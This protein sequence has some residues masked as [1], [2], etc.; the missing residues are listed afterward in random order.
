[1]VI[2]NLCGL[3]I[4]MN[5]QS[6]LIE[7]NILGD[8]IIIPAIMVEGKK[9][10]LQV[11]IIISNVKMSYKDWVLCM[12]LFPW[13]GLVWGAHVLDHSGNNLTEVPTAP[14]NM[15]I[16]EINL[17]NNHIQE[18]HRD[19][20]RNYTQLVDIN[21]DQNGLRAIHDGVFNHINTLRVL[22][23]QH[24]VIV[25][26]PTD[27][28]PST[29]ILHKILL[30]EAIAASQILTHPY[31]SSFT[32]LVGLTLHNCNIGNISDPFFPPNIQL[33][34]LGYSKVAKFPLLSISSPSLTYVSMPNQKFRTIPEKAVAGLFRLRFMKLTNNEINNFPNF[35]HCKRLT[36]IYLGKNK[37]SH[38]PR[39]HIKGLDKIRIMHLD[40]NLL[41]NMTDISSLAPLEEFTVGHNMISEIPNACIVGLLKMK[42][43]KCNDNYI[44]V[45][46]NIS[47]YFPL[48]KELFVQGN[49]LKSLPDM[50]DMQ[51][52]SLLTVAQNSYVCN[53]SLCWLR[54]LPWLNPD[55]T[56]LKDNPVCDQPVL[57]SDT[58]IVRFHPTDMEC[59]KGT[60]ATVFQ[61]IK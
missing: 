42:I 34:L 17:R 38:I 16:T 30:G 56:F 13:I 41:A 26:L 52:L 27:F 25:K 24:N 2:G 53:M 59:Y 7:E 51:Y 45:L 21:L 43:F 54:M 58:E 31:F 32:N 11:T 47:R 5:V 39:E 4:K 33:L 36:T 10:M 20:F 28:G 40:H 60:F 1:M 29:T 3:N 37:I 6:K 23:L 18:L 55:G 35:S 61:V 49:N 57:L 15:T 9:C 14:H 19:A 48:L 8:S 44:Y 22:S 46:P 12:Y 50:Y